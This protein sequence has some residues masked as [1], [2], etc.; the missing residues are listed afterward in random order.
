MV[1]YYKVSGDEITEVQAQRATFKSLLLPNGKFVNK[2]S[3]KA[4][5][6]TTERLA[7]EALMEKLEREHE[8][9]T[10]RVSVIQKLLRKYENRRS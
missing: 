7:V 4:R 5:Y 6:Y 2:L 8:A 10:Q 1:T 3:N 9:H